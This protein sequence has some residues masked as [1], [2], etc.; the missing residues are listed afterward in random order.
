[1]ACDL[2]LGQQVFVVAMMAAVMWMVMVWVSCMVVS[3]PDGVDCA[4]RSA[5]CPAVWDKMRQRRDELQQ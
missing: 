5:G 4:G 3:V 1:M 2:I